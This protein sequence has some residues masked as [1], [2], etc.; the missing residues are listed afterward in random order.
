[1]AGWKSIQLDPREPGSVTLVDMLDTYGLEYVSSAY[2]DYI[3]SYTPIFDAGSNEMVVHASSDAMVM[4]IVKAHQDE[5]ARRNG[6]SVLVNSFYSGHPFHA[7]DAWDRVEET[8]EV[9]AELNF[10]NNTFC[11]GFPVTFLTAVYDGYGRF[12]P[13][14]RNPQ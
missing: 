5:F 3:E 4:S 9:P 1:M 10:N 2:V 6:K 14:R 11:R 8:V 12:A 13:L 7:T